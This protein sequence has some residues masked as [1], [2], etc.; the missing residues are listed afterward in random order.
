MFAQ[1]FVVVVIMLSSQPRRL[2]AKASSLS[3]S[4]KTLQKLITK[5]A[6]NELMSKKSK[7]AN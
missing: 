1:L 3:D 6:L 5:A 4:A 2:L 7:K